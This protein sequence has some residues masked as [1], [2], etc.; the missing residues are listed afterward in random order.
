[1]E[2]EKNCDLNNINLVEIPQII[3]VE[4]GPTY[5]HTFLSNGNH[6]ICLYNE[7]GEYIGRR[8]YIPFHQYNEEFDRNGLNI[9]R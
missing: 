7:L 3:R 6:Y 9:K 5:V 2:E 1:M 8:D 4:R